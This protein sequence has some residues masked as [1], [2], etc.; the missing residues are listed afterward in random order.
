MKQTQHQT[1]M[2]GY[3]NEQFAPTK[4]SPNIHL[5]TRKIYTHLKTITNI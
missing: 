5:S 3:H 2:Y 4:L 1:T